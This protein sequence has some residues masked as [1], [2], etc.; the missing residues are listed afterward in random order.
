MLRDGQ[1][2]TQADTHVYQVYS[3]NKTQFQTE[4]HKT[5]KTDKTIHTSHTG[6]Q[7]DMHCVMNCI[8]DANTVSD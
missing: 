5:D 8:D 3:Q 2:Q 6:T 4:I 1:R 7:L